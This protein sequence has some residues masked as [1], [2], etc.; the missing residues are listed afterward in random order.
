MA[1]ILEGP[2]AAGK[3][4]LARTLSGQFGMRLVVAGGAPKTPAD[5]ERYC[6]DQLKA[7]ED[8]SAVI[9]RITPISHPIYN[10]KYRNAPNRAILDWY[11]N[12]ML[13]RP[14]VIVVYCRPPIEALMRPEKHQWKDYD[15]EE[16]KQKI[17]NNQMIYIEL[18]DEAFEKIPHLEYDY[19]V[20]NE[21]FSM[22]L[23]CMLAASQNSDEQ[24]FKL[25][26]L[27]FTRS[28]RY[29]AAYKR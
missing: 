13:E 12:K 16:D 1:I 24:L 26:E 25:K 6:K 28:Q 11:L 29:A 20:A 14:D 9:D 10:P 3:T 27:Q 5:V 21:D 2:D 4:T 23:V 19:T 22:H 17:L 7:C 15:T 8:R 18:Y